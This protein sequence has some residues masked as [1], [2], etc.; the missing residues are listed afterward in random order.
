M[1]LGPTST[2]IQSDSKELYFWE[3]WAW[4]PPL[5]RGFPCASAPGFST[6][7]SINSKQGKHLQYPTFIPLLPSLQ[8]SNQE[9]QHL[10]YLPWPHNHGTPPFL[11]SCYFMVAQSCHTH[12]S[13][14]F[15]SC[16]FSILLLYSSPFCFQYSLTLLNPFV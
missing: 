6:K 1:S 10:Q 16:P 5:E 9:Q 15:A 13:W 14:A 3:G 11:M 7:F 4:D 12:D 8:A 2:L